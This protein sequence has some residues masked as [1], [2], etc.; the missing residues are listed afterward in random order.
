M[1]K[2]FGKM[3]IFLLIFSFMPAL[4]LGSSLWEEIKNGKIQLVDLTHPLNEKNPFW[5]G[6]KYFP[7]KLK[8][9]ATLESDGVFSMSFCTPEHYGT[10]VDAPN[11]FGERLISV[12]QIDVEALFGPAIVIDVEKQVEKD[13]D[14][15]LTIDD[16]KD[17]ESK[18]GHIPKGAIVLMY[19]GWA[20]RW[21]DAEEYENMDDEG[22]MHFPG[23]SKEAVQF[24]V[25]ERD[26]KAIGIDTLSVDYG[27][28]KD[29]PVHH[30]SSEAGKYNL[31]NVAN[32]DKLPPL[33]ATLIIA[34]IKIEGGTG[35]PARIFALLPKK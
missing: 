27:P 33:G 10:H 15:R 14:Y 22:V 24:L 7:F 29:F 25:N 18:Y 23:F 1:G 13:Y 8:T 35:G 26:I 19:T 31:E 5:P 32:L 12:D 3:W 17:W 20:K 34:P 6:P 11:H 21:S 16:I 30:V 9:I 4:S 2:I 28:S